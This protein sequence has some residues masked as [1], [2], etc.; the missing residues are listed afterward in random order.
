MLATVFFSVKSAIGDLSIV[1]KNGLIKFCVGKIISHIDRLVFI[2][3]FNNNTIFI[4]SMHNLIPVE[5]F[6]ETPIFLFIVL[7]ICVKGHYRIQL[8]SQCGSR[9]CIRVIKFEAEN[10]LAYFLILIQIDRKSWRATTNVFKRRI[11]LKH[12]KI[13][14]LFFGRK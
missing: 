7:R 6:S 11:I 14:L 9:L 8:F 2:F 5:L 4:I 12:F 10:T 13:L 3:L 1:L